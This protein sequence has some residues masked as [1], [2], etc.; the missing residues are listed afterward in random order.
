MKNLSHFVGIDV[1]KNTLDFSILENN[2]IIGD[3]CVKN[4]T[5]GVQKFF[6]WANKKGVDLSK[7]LFCLEH[8]GNYTYTAITCLAEKSYTA[9]LANPTAIKKSLGLQRG[10]NDQKDARRI[11][12]YAARYTD[13]YQPILTVH[14]VLKT[15]QPMLTLRNKVVDHIKSYKVSLSENKGN[16]DEATYALL[17]KHMLPL[18]RARQ[19]EVKRVEKP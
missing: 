5:T 7:T 16:M 13:K 1:S 6:N 15:I 8:T 3:L 17:E 18:L 11:A 2:K 14:P 4:T 9:W 10:K 19:E 12:E